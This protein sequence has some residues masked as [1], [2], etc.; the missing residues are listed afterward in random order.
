MA[1]QRG[2]GEDGGEDGVYGVSVIALVGFYNCHHS[3]GFNVS[4]T[5][6]H[7]VE[8]FSVENDVNLQDLSITDN[9]QAE[10]HTDSQL[11]S[12][13]TVSAVCVYPFFWTTKI[14]F[15]SSNLAMARRFAVRIGL[16][17][18]QWKT[19]A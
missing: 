19:A 10:G 8:P 3:A 13:D 1:Q 16:S 18:P 4:Q 5:E 11:S 6:A 2:D 15:W 7:G 14:I 9:T 17:L 12:V